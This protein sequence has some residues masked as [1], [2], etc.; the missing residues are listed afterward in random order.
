MSNYYSSG[1]YG[2]SSGSNAGSGGDGNPYYGGGYTQPT[3]G[4][5]QQQQQQQPASQQTN[6]QQQQPPN[7]AF[8]QNT[9]YADPNQWKQQQ[10]QQQYGTPQQQPQQSLFTAP[11]M[12]V[13]AAGMSAVNSS[14]D[15]M[16]KLITPHAETFL[17]DSTARMIPGLERLMTALRRYFAV[18]NRYVKRKVQRIFFP[19]LC[20]SWQRQKFD[21]PIQ[22]QQ[23]NSSGAADM[24]AYALPH[25]D[26]NAPD[27]Y[28]P[29]M[30]LITYVLLCALAYGNAGQFSPEVLPQV[31]TWCF[32]SQILEVLLI[33]FGF[34]MM[35]APVP[36][37]DLFSYT[38]YKYFGLC[39]NML[40]AIA[41]THF[42][43]GTKTYYAFF[44]YTASAA[45]YFMLKTMANNIPLVVAAT[46]PKREM[47]VVG[48]A[49]SQFA[50]M[51][52]VSKTKFLT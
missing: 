11:S 6:Q 48:F 35:Q 47:M 9:S 17:K 25:S 1:G 39:F 30:S 31:A 8:G 14:P 15:A 10:P 38:G 51:Y 34:Y 18:D 29:F 19:F 40:G 22:Q 49:A 24:M 3:Q 4:Q 27:L 5:Q 21:T 46:G 43:L 45:S 2:G 44:L 36:F 52:F 13:L 33:R 20:K 23:Q 12:G 16:L 28:I 7:N 42:G 32:T 41:A 37:L 50:T 26:E